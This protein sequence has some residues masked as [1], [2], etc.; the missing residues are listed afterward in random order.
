MVIQCSPP[1]YSTISTRTRSVGQIVLRHF[2]DVL[3]DGYCFD[4]KATLKYS[5]FGC[6]GHFVYIVICRI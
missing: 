1:F 3:K 2:V 5:R 6:V 4:Q